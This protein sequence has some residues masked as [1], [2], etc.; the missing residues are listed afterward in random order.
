MS[1]QALKPSSS[2]LARGE[3]A[4]EPARLLIQTPVAI[5]TQ[6]PATAIAALNLINGFNYYPLPHLGP[7]TAGPSEGKGA[8][9]WLWLLG[10][11]LQLGFG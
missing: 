11:V 5:Q 1:P 3:Q 10:S 2:D 4:L 8:G 7:P 9:G 6:Q